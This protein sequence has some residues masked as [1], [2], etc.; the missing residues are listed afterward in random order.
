MRIFGQFRKTRG[1]KDGSTELKTLKP[2][3]ISIIVEVKNILIC[4]P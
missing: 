4:L 3:T 2:E 1:K